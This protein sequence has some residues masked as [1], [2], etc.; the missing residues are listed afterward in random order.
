M[1]K[2]ITT[3]ILPFDKF[4][5]AISPIRQATGRLAFAHASLN[6]AIKAERSWGEKKAERIMP[7]VVSE[8]QICARNFR[9][10]N[11]PEFSKKCIG[12]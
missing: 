5:R 2:A 1:I 10:A 8:N 9:V 11:E 6:R 4:L 7:L 12:C 3:L